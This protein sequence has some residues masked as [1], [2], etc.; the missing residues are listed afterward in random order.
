M[1]TI[2][3][4]TGVI[5]K[6]IAAALPAYTNHIRLVSRNPQKV[7][8]ADELVSADLL[9]EQQ[10]MDAVKGSEV[11]YLT[12]GLPYNTKT[13]ESDWPI[14]MQ[15]VLNACKAHGSR[16]VF[17][18]N[19]YCYGK[20]NGWMTEESP[21]HPT[22]AKGVV[23]ARLLQMIWNEVSRDHVQALVARAADFYGPN[24]ANSFA[25]VMVFDNLK[26][27][28]KAQWLIS[29]D[30]KH[31]FTYT[32]DAGKATA[33]LGNTTSAYNQSWHLPADHNA[34]NGREFISLAEAALGTN[35]GV[36]VL[37]KW[38]VRMVGLFVPVIKESIEMLYQNDSDYLFDSSKFRKAFPEFPVTTYQQGIAATAQSMK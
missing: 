37:P 30:V 23:R 11:V 21:V 27:G 2:L 35:K 20:V 34:L 10:V 17:F 9:N 19:V 8:P 26:K 12:A 22:S 13:W 32:P 28:K 33:L 31:S 24:T 3:G 4:S 18:D 36:M 15:N 1:Q 25:N 5:G 14:V 29:A 6:N 16:F 7:N 38:M